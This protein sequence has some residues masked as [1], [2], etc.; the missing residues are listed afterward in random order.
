MNGSA[1]TLVVGIGNLLMG[2][3]G[4]GCHAIA[5]LQ[6]DPSPGVVLLDAGTAV[7]NF[8]PEIERASAVL[9]IDAFHG[10]GTPG[11]LYTMDARSVAEPATGASLHDVGL[12]AALR[13]LPKEHLDKPLLLLG[14]EPA[15]IAYSTDLSPVVQAALPALLEAAREWIANDMPVGAL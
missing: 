13:W 11:S 10:G 2:D 6:R 8:L 4:V 5:A 1:T 12:S 7:I 3:D 9:F 14:V 15:L